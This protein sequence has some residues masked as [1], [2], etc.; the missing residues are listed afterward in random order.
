MDKSHLD[1]RASSNKDPSSR[2]TDPTNCP[3]PVTNLPLC[4]KPW[5]SQVQRKRDHPTEATTPKSLCRPWDGGT[6][7]PKT[8]QRRHLPNRQ[9]EAPSRTS[10]MIHK[11][12]AQTKKVTLLTKIWTDA[13]CYY[14]QILRNSNSEWLIPVRGGNSYEKDIP[15]RKPPPKDPKNTWFS[16]NIASTYKVIRS[17]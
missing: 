6:H 4:K 8:G 11:N 9:P 12:A 15:T 3:I 1:L 16:L 17:S 5:T 2:Q 10:T 14:T 13:L 7:A